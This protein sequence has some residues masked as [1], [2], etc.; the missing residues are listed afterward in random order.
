MHAQVMT[1]LEGDSDL[2]DDGHHLVDLNGLALALLIDVG[3][4][5]PIDPLAHDDEEGDRR[6]ARA[7]RPHDGLGFEDVEYGDQPPVV[8]EGSLACSRLGRR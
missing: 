4:R 8:D 3:E 7:L 6:C 2:A 1:V 5:A